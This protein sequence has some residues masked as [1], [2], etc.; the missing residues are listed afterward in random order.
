MIRHTYKTGEYSDVISVKKIEHWNGDEYIL[1]WQQYD[2]RGRPDG[3]PYKAYIDGEDYEVLRI[4]SKIENE[5]GV[6]TELMDDLH[7]AEYTR[8]SNDCERNFNDR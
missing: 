1:T 4:R 3:E 8:I 2:K 5:Y 6:P 7:D